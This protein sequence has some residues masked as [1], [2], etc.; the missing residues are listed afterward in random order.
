MGIGPQVQVGLDLYQIHIQGSSKAQGSSDGGHYLA[1]K[2]VKICVGWALNIKVSMTDVI[3][4]LMSTTMKA[5]SE[6]FRVVWV[7]RMEL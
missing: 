6:C 5:Q 3:D 7:V 2:T 1:N 4:G